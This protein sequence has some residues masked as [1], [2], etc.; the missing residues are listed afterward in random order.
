MSIAACFLIKL[1]HRRILVD[2][3]DT[4][5]VAPCTERHHIASE[6]VV[7]GGKT[8]TG[9]GRGCA[10]GN[11]TEK[12]RDSWGKEPHDSK[13]MTVEGV[14]GTAGGDGDGDEEKEVVDFVLS[15][16]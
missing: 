1:A 4:L 13:G 15:K 8:W 5:L 16:A 11:E 7:S 10:R 14:E 12:E 2:P 3:V 9:V 6:F